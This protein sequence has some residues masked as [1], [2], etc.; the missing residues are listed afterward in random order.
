MPTTFPSVG[1]WYSTEEAADKMQ[2]SPEH[3]SRLCREG[4]LP[5]TMVGNRYLLHEKIVNRWSSNV[6]GLADLANGFNLEQEV[7]L[8]RE[9]YKNKPLILGILAPSAGDAASLVYAKA[10][11]KACD[12]VGFELYAVKNEL[13]EIKATIRRAND[14]SSVHGIFVFYPIFKGEK[15]K[16]LRN[17]IDPSK[18][19]EGLSSYWWNKLYSN[20]RYLDKE[21]KKK[22]ILPCTS[23]GILKTLI[24]VHRLH[25]QPEQTF[26]GKHIT[27]FNRSDVVGGPLAYMLRNDDATVYSFDIHGGVIMRKHREEEKVT[28]EFALSASDIIITGVPSKSFEKIRGEEIGGKVTCINFSFIENFEE[29]AKKKARI[30]I[31]RVGPMTIAMCIRNA[32]RLYDHN[33]D[34]YES[35][36]V[37]NADVM[38]QT[39]GTHVY[40]GETKLAA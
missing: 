40:L 25:E 14:D 2:L 16:M 24:R 27:I 35:I 22:A 21:Q 7:F 13:E 23:L 34:I 3:V 36:D 19:V 9:Q 8:K 32:I 4:K 15:D 29:C 18:D 5:S 31:P 39:Y 1:L 6:V 26:S 38:K 28:R 20:E 17:A 30:Y 11:K 37:K 10:L 33:K 12:L